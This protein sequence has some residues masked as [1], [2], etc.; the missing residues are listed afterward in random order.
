MNID[1]SYSNVIE[2]N[3][4]AMFVLNKNYR[5]YIGLKHV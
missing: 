5:Q 3:L 4:K 1:D 2:G